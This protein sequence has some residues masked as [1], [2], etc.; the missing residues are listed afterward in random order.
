MGVT[1]FPPGAPIQVYDP[2]TRR[3]FPASIVGAGYSE[4]QYRVAYE[5]GSTQIIH[6]IFVYGEGET[7]TPRRDPYPHDK[8]G[9]TRKAKRRASPAKHRGNNAHIRAMFER[10][11]E[12]VRSRKA[13]ET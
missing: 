2:A 13:Q 1:T 9:P 10:A 7:I 12:R 8:P 11:R 3:V 4:D 6:E 5:D